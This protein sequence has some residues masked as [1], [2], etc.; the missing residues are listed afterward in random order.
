PREHMVMRLLVE[1]HTRHDI[2]D[3]LH[4][5]ARTVATHRENIMRKLGADSIAHLVALALE[6]GYVSYDVFHT[7]SGS[8]SK[9]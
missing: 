1:G 6:K 5:E 9:E 7:G 2:A 4:M 3:R 8:K